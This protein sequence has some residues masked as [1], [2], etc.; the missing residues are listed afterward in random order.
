MLQRCAAALKNSFSKAALLGILVANA[1]LFIVPVRSSL[2]LF[3]LNANDF[4]WLGIF[5]SAVAFGLVAAFVCVYSEGDALEAS[6]VARSLVLS[7]LT[8]GLAAAIAFIVLAILL[9]R[10]SPSE[11]PEFHDPFWGIQKWNALANIVVEA[12]LLVAACGIVL[13]RPNSA[14]PWTP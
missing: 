11:P 2:S 5:G 7:G 3:F 10:V 4:W 6:P 9:D 8:A 14:L 13:K 12:F 1:V